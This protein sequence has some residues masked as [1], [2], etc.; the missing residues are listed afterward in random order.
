MYK[1]NASDFF[2]W[3]YK[4]Y[5][6]LLFPEKIKIIPMENTASSAVRMPMLVILN[7]ALTSGFVSSEK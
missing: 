5:F 2:L 7:I 3:G 1:N 4:I 6:I